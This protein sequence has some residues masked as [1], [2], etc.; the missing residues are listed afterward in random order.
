[1]AKGKSTRRSSGF[2][3][4]KVMKYVRLAALLAPVAFEVMKADTMQ[5]KALHVIE[6]TTG[7]NM[8]TGTF[9]GAALIRGWGPLL[10]ATLVTYGVPKIAGMIRGM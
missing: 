4:Q 9:N 6:N 10:A 1:M 3:T 5:N 8:N 2:N 7:F